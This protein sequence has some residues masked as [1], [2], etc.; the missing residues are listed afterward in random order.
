MDKIGRQKTVLLLAVPHILIWIIIMF[1]ESLYLFYLSRVLTG[2]ADSIIF[3]ALPAFIGEIS[4]PQVRGSWGNF[5]TFAIY[6]GQ[7]LV[8]TIGGYLDLKTTA[9][10]F[11]V[12]PILFFLTFAL[13]PESPYYLLIMK[14]DEEAKQSLRF[15][16]RTYNVDEEFKQISS[17]VQRQLSESSKWNELVTNP[18]HRRALLAG[19]FCRFAQQFAGT[20]AFATYCHFIFKNAG[21]DLSYKLSAS[22][23]TTALVI[24]NL[25]AGI[26]LDR[27]GRRLA[28]IIS[29]G[30]CT[31][32]LFL[33]AIFFYLK[34][35]T[36]I[37]VSVI[38]WFP[39]V[40]MFS[41]VLAYSIGIGIVPTLI[42]G[43]LFSA[44]VKAK[45]V[46]ALNV[47]FCI[48]SA[49]S[50]KIFQS[51]VSGFGFYSPFALYFVCTI[52]NTV[53]CFYL[54]P[55]TRGKTLEEIQQ[56]MTKKERK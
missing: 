14:R 1:S 35:F 2:F 41:F 49:G 28:M 31:V 19:I 26:I 45:G 55:E 7:M 50:T 42:I 47:F 11:S 46:C 27:M 17:D 40:V 6:V 48:F 37:D 5:C 34:D 15:Y 33:A 12:F 56:T 24:A 23:Y 51:M 10:I 52:C 16:R 36:S 20:S 39:L 43:E 38:N 8:V 21:T 25:I 9:Y 54:I 18:T 44:S 22:F 3:T 32:V 30:S 29:C 4:T 53:L 13:I